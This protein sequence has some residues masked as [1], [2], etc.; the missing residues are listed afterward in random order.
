MSYLYV[1]YTLHLYEPFCFR[2]T[3]KKTSGTKPQKAKSAAARNKFN[4]H[5]LYVWTDP[6][7]EQLCSCDIGQIGNRLL[8]WQQ[9][10]IT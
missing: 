9:L 10:M 6:I 1:S 8:I 4:G 5:K 3:E 7:I 2:K